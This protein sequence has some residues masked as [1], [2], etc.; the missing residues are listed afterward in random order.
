[1]PETQHLRVT[2]TSPMQVNMEEIASL[3]RL[4]DS[5]Q[6]LLFADMLSHLCIMRLK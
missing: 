5:F 1:M 2:S 3:H 4:T 6:S